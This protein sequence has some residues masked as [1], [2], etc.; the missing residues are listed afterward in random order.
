MGEVAEDKKGTRGRKVNKHRWEKKWTGEI[1]LEGEERRNRKEQGG[2]RG[3]RERS[4]GKEHNG[5][6]KC[7]LKKK[8]N[9]S[10]FFRILKSNLIKILL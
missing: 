9:H 7:A 5:G 4:T 8:I 1:R 3:K 10:L 6:T 2:R